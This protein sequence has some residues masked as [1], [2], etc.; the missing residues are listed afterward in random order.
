[1]A[2]KS[3]GIGVA[4]A[5]A[6]LTGS[7]GTAGAVGVGGKCGTFVNG[8]CDPGLFCDHK[9]GTCALIGGTG[10]CVQ[11]P[12]VCPLASDKPRPNVILPV[13]G[14]NG[15]TYGNDCERIKAMEQKA[16]NGRCK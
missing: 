14:C 16:H 3:H 7:M 13:C 10:K 1:M 15:T 12:A 2:L 11:I 9:P 6:L 5:F 4:L 8:F